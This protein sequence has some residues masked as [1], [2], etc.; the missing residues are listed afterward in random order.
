M[1]YNIAILHDTCPAFV[2]ESLPHCGLTFHGSICKVLAR[3]H[4]DLTLVSRPHAGCAES[5]VLGT[6]LYAIDL[7]MQSI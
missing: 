4:F 5:E 3:V 6:Q 2:M 7:S 1:M